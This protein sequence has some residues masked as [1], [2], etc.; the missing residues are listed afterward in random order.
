MSN[1]TEKLFCTR[2]KDN[3]MGDLIGGPVSVKTF[4]PVMNQEPLSNWTW[5]RT[6]DGFRTEILKQFHG[7][8]PLFTI[9]FLI[10]S[11][12]VKIRDIPYFI[13]MFSKLNL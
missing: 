7:N 9:T 2:H 8:I 5:A 13:F 12:Q 1:Q 11:S 4:W 6:G 10:L 3:S